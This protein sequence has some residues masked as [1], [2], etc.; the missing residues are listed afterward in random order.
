[1][2][3]SFEGWLLKWMFIYTILIFSETELK[4]NLYWN[5]LTNSVEKNKKRAVRHWSLC[6]SQILRAKVSRRQN[7]KFHKNYNLKIYTIYGSYIG[8]NWRL[9]CWLDIFISHMPHTRYWYFIIHMSNTGFNLN[10]TVV[11]IPATL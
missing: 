6:H 9:N 10:I 2:R 8:L 11:Q 3:Y 7:L 5:K 1:M 4:E